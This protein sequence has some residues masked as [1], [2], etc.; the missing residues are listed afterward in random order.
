I[1]DGT[2][3][4]GDIATDA[5]TSVKI[6]DGT[7]AT[8]DIANDAVTSAKIVDGTIVTG[9]LANDAVTSAKIVDGTIVASDIATDAVTTAKILDLNVTTSKLAH[10]SVTTAK[11]ADANV[12]DTKIATD[13]VTTAKI[14][15]SAVT[16]AKINDG[17]VTSVKLGSGLTLAGTT[18]FSGNI[19]M[20]A[21]KITNLGAPTVGSDAATKTYVDAASAAQTLSFSND[22]ISIS[23]GNTVAISLSDDQALSLSGD[24]MYISGGNSVSLAD[25]L[26]NTD[27]QTVS[28]S[29][30]TL[31][32]SG[33]NNVALNSVDDQTLS[34]VGKT[35]SIDDGNS[36]NLFDND[37][38]NELI[39]SVS[40]VSDSLK[41]TD[42]SGTYTVGKFIMSGTTAGGSLTGTY[43][44]PTLVTGAVTQTKI[45]SNAVTTDKIM[46]RNV[47]SSDLDTNLTL[48]GQ[49]FINGAIACKIKSVTSFDDP[50]TAGEE[51]VI[52]VDATLGAMQ[53][54]LPAAATVPNRTYIIKK[55]DASGNAVTINPDGVETI[56]G[57]L[58]PTL[59]TQYNFIRVISTGTTWYIIG[60]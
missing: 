24:S 43:P 34:L 4:A 57:V 26:D 45:Q 23:G 14:Q 37:S 30:D 11:I 51:V 20:G 13:A 10:A 31:Y 52:V 41:I 54:R 27:A 5:V 19:A 12:T 8:G 39:A 49:T 28:L 7:I 29:N 1:L 55:I 46:D 58:T 38:T 18:T 15:N 21:N 56:D 36:V 3:V 17:A 35:L 47:Q 48:I 16:T 6:L 32:I 33:G 44:N 2:I 59:I 9:D 42:A 25:Y 40:V 22:S 53:V 50:Y 60:Q